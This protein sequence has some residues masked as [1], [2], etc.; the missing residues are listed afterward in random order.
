MR[1]MVLPIIIQKAIERAVPYIS[2]A[3]RA[4]GRVVDY[5]YTRPFL[6]RNIN[7][8]V[9]RGVKHGLAG[10]QILGGLQEL[11]TVGNFIV[12]DGVPAFQLSKTYNNR[13]ARGYLDFSRSKR[14]YC[15][16]RPN[17]YRQKSSYRY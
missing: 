13:K 5:T 2:S 11:N 6:T 14:K 3:L 4:Q 8:S 17:K 16:V 9:R 1:K 7:P 10:G 12:P 15:P